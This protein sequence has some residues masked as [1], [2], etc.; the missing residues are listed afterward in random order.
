MPCAAQPLMHGYLPC[1]LCLVIVLSHTL[2]IA[3]LPHC[4]GSPHVQAPL[5]LLLPAPTPR[6]TRLSFAP[7]P[8]LD[9]LRPAGLRPCRVTRAHMGRWG[10]LQ[11]RHGHGSG[12]AGSA[13]AQG[14]AG[15]YAE[16]ADGGDVV[17]AVPGPRAPSPGPEAERRHQA[18]AAK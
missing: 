18:H 16:G 12:G 2:P 10:L 6:C 4:V 8:F 1:L 17:V 9:T 3:K 13:R 15:D 5:P 14:D 11:H 7:L